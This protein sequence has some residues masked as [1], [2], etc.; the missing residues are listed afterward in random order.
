MLESTLSVM[1]FLSFC[2]Y[3]ETMN[4]HIQKVWT[5][6]VPIKQFLTLE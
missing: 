5:V 3:M 6:S 1:L 2:L 4:T